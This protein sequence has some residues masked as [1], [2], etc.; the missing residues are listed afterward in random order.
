MGIIMKK[1]YSIGETSRITGLSVQTLRD[2]CSYGLITPA[3]VNQEN[4][5]RFF[6]FDQFHILDRI[7]YLRSLELP[8]A[9]IKKILASD[10][11]EDICVSLDLQS[12]K[13]DREIE[14]LTRKK[15]HLDW[16]SGYFRYYSQN[17]CNW[18][19][20]VTHFPERIILF[21][22]CEN[23][24]DI[25][26]IEVRLT[27]LKTNYTKMGFSYLRQFGYLLDYSSILS[28]DWKPYR[29]FIYCSKIPKDYDI[30]RDEHLMT[31]PEGNY[32]CCSFWL[33][34][35]E[36]LNISQLESYFQGQKT[37]PFVLAN[38]Y[39]DNLNDYR[40]CPYELQFLLQAPANSSE[41]I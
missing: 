9:E 8:L 41:S 39:E 27:K 18:L 13:I 3:Y 14:E 33:R 1:L 38:E 28:C 23:P 35:L 15:H 7:K 20:H 36:D 37:P 12:E 34:H 4:G 29:H 6:S 2:Y 24:L 16:Y 5:Y 26:A 22:D 10:S 30:K 40:Y 11:M 31:L 21:T 17:A 19:P 32:F 25:E